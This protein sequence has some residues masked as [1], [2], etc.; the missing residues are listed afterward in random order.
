[1]AAQTLYNKWR[2]QTFAATIGQDHVT[3]TLRNALARPDQLA[4]AYLFCGPR[5]TGKT[6][7]ARVLAKALNCAQGLQPEPCN[8]CDHCQ[9]INRGAQFD[10][11]IE[12]DGASHT[13]V[14]DIRDLREKVSRRPGEGRYKVYIIDE[15]HMLSTNAFNALLKTL[16]EPP[17]HVRFI[18][19]TTEP[20]KVLATVLSRCQRFDFKPVPADTLIRH[21]R[22][23]AEQE[24]L[25]VEHDALEFI[26]HSATGSVRDALSL[27]DQVMAF[28]GN[29]IAAS[30]L[31]EMLGLS[32]SALVL[33]LVDALLDDD[34]TA[35][36]ESIQAASE[37]GADLREFGHQVVEVLRAMLL[38]QSGLDPPLIPSL[39]Q[40]TKPAAISR[41]RRVE[42]A[43]LV[44]W[45]Q[46]FVEADTGV[47]SAAAQPQL[48]LELAAVQ[49]ILVSRGLVSQ[50]A[51]PAPLPAPDVAVPKPIREVREVAPKPRP[52]PQQR[53]AKADQP[54]KRPGPEPPPAD[55]PPSE[56]EPV[57]APGRSS[58]GAG[59][60]APAKGQPLTTAALEAQWPAVL[61]LLGRRRSVTALLRD[62][63]IRSVTA[64]EVVLEFAYPFHAEQVERPENRVLVEQAIQ[65]ILGPSLRIQARVKNARGRPDRSGATG[66]Q[67][68]VVRHALAVF[69]GATIIEEVG[70]TNERAAAH[71]KDGDHEYEDAAEDA[72]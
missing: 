39:G 12:I 61:S 19:A 47:R 52:R 20:E 41:S 14:D 44:Q 54:T 24:G 70:D 50:A 55:G 65:R 8:Q 7:T 6:T 30:H 56:G 4:H 16:E 3:R 15:V 58:A 43:P 67:D 5:G 53:L 51:A 1:M 34:V 26:A 31:R 2:P 64:D 38:A 10:L 37:R 46:C 63:A 22:M 71:G 18:F 28:A 25:Q 29:T 45:I 66:R 59:K 9:A 69:P 13:G 40:E 68:P 42:L 60:P 49:S 57:A 17:P 36:V 27:L 23:V 62:A 72:E 11:L 33:A 35:A 32:D 21:L 48:P